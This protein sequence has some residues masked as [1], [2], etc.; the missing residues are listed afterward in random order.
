MKTAEDILAN[1]KRHLITTA[2]NKTIHEA[3]EVMNA[4]KVGAILL[5]EAEEHKIVGIWTERDL[6]RNVMIEGFNPKAAINC[7][8]ACEKTARY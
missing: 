4:H 1:K 5:T 8:L 3:L 7:C 6:M 2:S